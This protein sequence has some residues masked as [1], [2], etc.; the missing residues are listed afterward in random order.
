[1]VAPA[2][3][4]DTK[5]VERELSNGVLCSSAWP[6]IY[7]RL[8]DPSVRRGVAGILMRCDSQ[9][10]AACQVPCCNEG[11]SKRVNAFSHSRA[12]PQQTMLLC[13]F[14]RF[15]LRRANGTVLIEPWIET[16]SRYRHPVLLGR[17]AAMKQVWGCS[18]YSPAFFCHISCPPHPSF[19]SL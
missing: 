2:K 5:R 8:T 13:W 18:C 9:T 7:L 1:M 12:T 6:L 15:P 19:S 10:W 11:G 16:H 14:V 17:Q 4:Q 3:F